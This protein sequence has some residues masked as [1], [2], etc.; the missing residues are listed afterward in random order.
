MNDQFPSFQSHRRTDV[1]DMQLFWAQFNNAA[2]RIQNGGWARQVTKSDFAISDAV[3]GVNMRLGPA[4]FREM[5]WHRAAE[6]RS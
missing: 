5:H 3:S 2:Q 4:A 1:G 6:W